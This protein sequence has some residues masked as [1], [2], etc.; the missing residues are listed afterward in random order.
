MG[1]PAPFVL[2]SDFV[3][4]STTASVLS[5]FSILLRK[6]LKVFF[7]GSCAFTS[8]SE[9]SF[10]ATVSVVSF[11]SDLLRKLPNALFIFCAVSWV[12]TDL[13]S[14]VLAAE[15]SVLLAEDCNIRENE[16][17]I[18]GTDSDDDDASD[19]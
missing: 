12:G 9:S 13:G 11:F 1:L 10:V 19:F 8:D 15:E 5:F 2:D 14:V 16:L 17:L 7:L 6:V 3:L 4:L 18:L